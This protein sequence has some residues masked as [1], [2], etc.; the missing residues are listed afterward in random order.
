MTSRILTFAAV[1][2]AAVLSATHAQATLITVDTNQG[3]A[4][5]VLDTSSGLQWLKLSVTDHLSILQVEA[6]AAPGGSLQGYRYAD[7]NELN[8]DL[9][10]PFFNIPCNDLGGFGPL[11]DETAVDEFFDLFGFIEEGTRGAYANVFPEGSTERREG[12]ITSFAFLSEPTRFYEYDYQRL[13]LNPDRLNPPAFHWLVSHSES[14]AVPEPSTAWLFGL[15][16]FGLLARAR[17]TYR[18]R[19]DRPVP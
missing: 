14:Q 13:N 7:I 4:T 18:R 19:H 9:I 8:C 5:A 2:A 11:G 1:A 10:S 15:G 12:Y 3:P 17:M 16:A 6:A